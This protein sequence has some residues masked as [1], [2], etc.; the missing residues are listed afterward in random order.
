MLQAAYHEVAL[1]NS[2]LRAENDRL[3][4]EVEKLQGLLFEAYKTLS[5][6]PSKEAVAAVLAPDGKG[7]E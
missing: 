4:A 3:R 1:T 5:T 7:G 6:V 2:R